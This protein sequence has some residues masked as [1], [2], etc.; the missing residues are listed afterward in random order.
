MFH[1]IQFS[2]NIGNTVSHTMGTMP[3]LKGLQNTPLLNQG[4]KLLKYQNGW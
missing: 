4:D 3:F 1:L 2:E